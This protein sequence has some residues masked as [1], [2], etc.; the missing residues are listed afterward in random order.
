[1]SPFAV[2]WAVPWHTDTA[3]RE[4]EIH[5]TERKIHKKFF[6]AWRKRAIEEDES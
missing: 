1:L 3:R 2:I 6:Y 4:C 5:K